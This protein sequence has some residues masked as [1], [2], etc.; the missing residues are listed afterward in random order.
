MC[1]Y[2]IMSSSKIDLQSLIDIQKEIISDVNR[3]P[4]GQQSTESGES[5]ATELNN[6]LDNLKKALEE[7]GR[8][9]E[10]I[11][12]KQGDIY[13]ILQTENVRLRKDAGAADQAAI[14]QIRETNM[15]KSYILR[16]QAYNKLTYLV[17]FSVL[18]II[19]LV[20]EGRYLQ[21]LPS[22][23][24]EFLYV[25]IIGGTIIAALII[26][27]NI[28]SRDKMDFSKFD[29]PGPNEITDAEK[30]K[31]KE[32]TIESGNLMGLLN[33]CRGSDCCNDGTV[34]IDGKCIVD[35]SN[36]ESTNT[37]SEDTTSSSESFSL[38]NEFFK[39]SNIR[40]YDPN[41]LLHFRF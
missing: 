5:Y 36:E 20:M 30:N 10:N 7:S 17:I 35:I 13:D 29:L 25:I 28:S 33:V 6:R 38:F 11:I 1:N 32:K 27:V 40:P 41:M 9:S 18:L 3:I 31:L 2:N 26:F 16:Y 21:Y 23:I 22:Y 39:Q 14:G 4:I 12:L 8:N 34:F 37:E 15:N 24:V 19:L